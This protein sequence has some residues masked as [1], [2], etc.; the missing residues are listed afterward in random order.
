MPL[1][2]AALF[3]QLPPF[4]F[5]RLGAPNDIKLFGVPAELSGVRA[6]HRAGGSLPWRSTVRW[7]TRRGSPVRVGRHITRFA[8]GEQYF[9]HIPVPDDWPRA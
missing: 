6:A 9:F 8:D 5:T 7:S 3:S 4:Q 2:S 1:M